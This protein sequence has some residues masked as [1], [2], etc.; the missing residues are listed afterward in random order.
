MLGQI[1]NPEGRDARRGEGLEIECRHECTPFVH[2]L[3][4][5]K[6]RG[7]HRLRRDLI[8]RVDWHDVHQDTERTRCC[9]FHSFFRRAFAPAHRTAKV[10]DRDAM[11]LASHASFETHARSAQDDAVIQGPKRTTIHRSVRFASEASNSGLMK[12]ASPPPTTEFLR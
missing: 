1:V 12:I 9:D 4:K 8:A 5:K 6:A 10:D 2:S 7:R 3:R 11:G